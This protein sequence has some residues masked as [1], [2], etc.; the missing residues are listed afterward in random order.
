MP[1]PLP[2]GYSYE[3]QFDEDGNINPEWDDAARVLA[4]ACDLGITSDRELAGVLLYKG[5]VAGATWTAAD[6][7]SYSF[8]VAL[9]PNHRGK[10]IG[11]YL[12]DQV[13]DIPD[14]LTECYENIKHEIY[15]VNPQ[16]EAMLKARG[17][18]ISEVVQGGSV[19]IE[20]PRLRRAAKQGFDVSTIWYHATAAKFAQ[21]DLDRTADG[22]IWLSN[23]LDGLKNGEYAATGSTYILPV[24][25][26][27]VPLAN[28]DEY[29]RYMGDELRQQGKHGALL[30][31]CMMLF[32]PKDIRSVADDFSPKMANQAYLIAPQKLDQA[33][34]PA[35]EVVTTD[36][37]TPH[38]TTRP[39]WRP[40]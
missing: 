26:R 12:L 38:T 24:F 9:L 29:D 40:S 11:G 16:M 6:E 14:E 10:G 7:V 3:N 13:L 34:L 4:K 19:M 17:F 30:D 31:D 28:E 32:D 1:M 39:T 21:F 15:V 37:V 23:N 25:V 27:N 33:F 36:A 8:D 22:C 2:P 35:K 20:N 5:K 18:E